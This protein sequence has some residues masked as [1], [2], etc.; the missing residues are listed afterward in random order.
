MQTPCRL[1]GL[2][3][4]SLSTKVQGL[5]G[6][7]AWIKDQTGP[8]LLSIRTPLKLPVPSLNFCVLARSLYGRSAKFS[9]E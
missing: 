3:N 1:A 6:T 4:Q 5:L 9:Y 8:D 7:T 2:T